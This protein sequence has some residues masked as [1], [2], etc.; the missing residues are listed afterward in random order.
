MDR[1]IQVPKKT[2]PCLMQISS[3]RR[4]SLSIY[5]IF[6]SFSFIESFH[7]YLDILWENGQTWTSTIF[8]FS[9]SYLSVSLSI[10]VPFK[11]SHAI[12][13]SYVHILRLKKSNRLQNIAE[14][15]VVNLHKSYLRSIL[16]VCCCGNVMVKKWKDKKHKLTLTAKSWNTN[17]LSRKKEIKVPLT[18]S[19]KQEIL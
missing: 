10:V 7:I 17:N 19:E 4:I 11:Q 6:F 18:I 15:V 2:E 5:H 9:A 14:E 16:S 12:M 3:R 1:F 8:T 13:S